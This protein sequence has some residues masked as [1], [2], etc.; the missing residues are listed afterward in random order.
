M[1]SITLNQFSL[2]TP[3]NQKLFGPIQLEISQGSKWILTG[4]NGIGKSTLLKALIN[5]WSHYKGKL[6][7]PFQHHA[8]LPQIENISLHIPFTL[9]D[10]IDIEMNKKV[11]PN[12]I[13]SL[14]F[15]PKT[16]LPLPWNSA[17]G[18][19]RKRALLT[20][21]FFKPS[22]ILFLDEPFNHLDLNTTQLLVK[23]LESDELKNKTILMISHDKKFMNPT[24]WKT[25]DLEATDASTL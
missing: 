12:E 19:E 11:N 3:T 13:E 8:Y 7:N 25:F 23:K 1:N 9:K 5:E 10:V 15:L 17:S 14:G 20:R 24:L 2:F 4:P 22:E 18:G 21:F 16:K 6:H